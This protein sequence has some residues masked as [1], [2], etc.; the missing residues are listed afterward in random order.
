M[1]QFLCIYL[2]RVVPGS[3]KKGMTLSRNPQSFLLDAHLVTKVI[4]H[5]PPMNEL[6]IK[7]QNRKLTSVKYNLHAKRNSK[8]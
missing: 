8:L 4:F 3:S 2:C 7:L 1:Q 6:N 5:L